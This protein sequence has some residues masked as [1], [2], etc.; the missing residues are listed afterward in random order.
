MDDEASKSGHADAGPVQRP[1]G[2]LDPKRDELCTRVMQEIDA[3]IKKYDVRGLAWRIAS[4]ASDVCD[5]WVTRYELQPLLDSRRIRLSGRP[6]SDSSI[7]GDPSR[8]WSVEL[9]AREIQRHYADRL[10]PNV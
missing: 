1:V 2:R 6:Y 10:T 8:Y 7:C 9:T 5:G 4:A 3:Y